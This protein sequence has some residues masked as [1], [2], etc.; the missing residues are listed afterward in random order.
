MKGF[1]LWKQMDKI[2]A[3]YIEEAACRKVVSRSGNLRIMM[4]LVAS[5]ACIIV[6]FVV[7]LMPKEQTPKE[8]A[9]KEQ[10]AAAQTTEELAV[11]LQDEAN[12]IITMETVQQIEKR[13]AEL[14]KEALAEEKVQACNA[15]LEAESVALH[16]KEYSVG[17]GY[18]YVLGEND[19]TYIYRQYRTIGEETAFCPYLYCAYTEEIYELGSESG[20]EAYLTQTGSQSKEVKQKIAYVQEH[21]TEEEYAGVSGLYVDGEAYV[22]VRLSSDER[23]AELENQGIDCELVEYSYAELKAKKQALLERRE[24]LKI[25]VC[26]INESENVVYV[27]SELFDTQLAE[28]LSE[29]EMRGVECIRDKE[30]FYGLVLEGEN[31][32]E[33]DAFLALV[34]E[35]EGRWIKESENVRYQQEYQV[36]QQELRVA[37]E[38]LKELY[39]L[40]SYLQL[41]YLV[42]GDLEYE[43]YLNF[44]TELN[45][46]VATLPKEEISEEYESTPMELTDVEMLELRRMLAEYKKKYPDKT[47]EELYELCGYKAWA[48]NDD[49]S[50][51]ERLIWMLYQKR[52]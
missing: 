40:Y 23:R 42:A 47:Y 3:E 9:L 32:T 30:G 44:E 34:Q 20:I 48:E 11:S 36:Y 35:E 33:L 38:Q 16:Y 8:Q 39:P 19:I 5:V 17:L 51:H 27:V 4:S 43:C 46:F 1:E 29:E 13:L 14:P 41:Y 10:H 37:L 26:F 21:L 22:Y 2:D 50:V 31:I 28:H 15:I 25:D 12:G 6:I 49:A 52:K 7:C 18:Y 24:E 45:T